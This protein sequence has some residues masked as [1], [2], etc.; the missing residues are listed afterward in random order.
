MFQSVIGDIEKWINIIFI[1]RDTDN[2]HYLDASFV[3]N[4]YTIENVFSE[5]Y[6]SYAKKFSSFNW[7]LYL[8]SD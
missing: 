4:C 7:A 1:D 6:Y 2:I 8:T 5:S 3:D